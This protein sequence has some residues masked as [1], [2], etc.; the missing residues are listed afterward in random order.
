MSVRTSLVALATCVVVGAT[1]LGTSPASANVSQGYIAGSGTIIDDW[2][3][4]GPLW[5]GSKYRTSNAAGL[6]QYVLWAEGATE[7]NGSAY[8]YAD[9]DCDFGDNT[10]YATKKLQSRWGVD[11]DG[12]VGS[13]TFSIADDHL[14]GSTGRVTY[15]GKVRAVTF[16]RT[17]GGAYRFEN[18]EAGVGSNLWETANYQ[19][20]ATCFVPGG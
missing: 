9:I 11:P 2:G 3:D 12:A 17:S 18:P 19:T 13:Q 6:W 1:A 5:S 10:T 8:D 20:Y 14:R 4:E 16:I 7:Q 15:F